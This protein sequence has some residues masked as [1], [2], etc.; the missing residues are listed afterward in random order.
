[1]EVIARTGAVDVSV[2][3][4]RRPGALGIFQEEE[5]AWQARGLGCTGRAEGRGMWVFYGRGGDSGASPGPKAM[6]G[7]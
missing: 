7:K 1:M 2:E 6:N 5:V 4:M 3:A